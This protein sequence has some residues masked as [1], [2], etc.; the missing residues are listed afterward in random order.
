MTEKMTSR[1]NVLYGAAAAGVATPLLA[2]CGSDSG[3]GTTGVVADPATA[4]SDTAST[5]GSNPAASSIPTADIP[6]G[7]GKIFSDTKT[8]VTQPAAGDFKAFT[9]V[10]THTGCLVSSISDG[11]I[12]CPCHGSRYSITDGSVQG[13]PA[14]APLAE[15][16][17]TVKGADLTVS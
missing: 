13:G 1:R 14:P 12:N 8:V 11:T 3:T 6:V 16:T 2:A 10:C 17:V 15:K 4:P 5:S 9:A 7:G